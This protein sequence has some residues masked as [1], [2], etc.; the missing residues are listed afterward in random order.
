MSRDGP[1]KTFYYEFEISLIG[2]TPRIWCHF[3]SRKNCTFHELHDTI[4]KACGWL[5]YHL[6]E[7]RM[8]TG[9]EP[10][11]RG[12]WIACSPFMQPM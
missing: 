2:V 12:E 10:F 9:D 8:Y 4:Q 3:Q 11:D 5:D 7:F 1:T 6:Y